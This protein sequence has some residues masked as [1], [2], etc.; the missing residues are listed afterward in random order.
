MVR[1]TVKQLEQQIKLLELKN[2]ALLAQIDVLQGEVQYYVEKEA[3]A[4]L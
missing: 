4:D 2:K 1:K 3:G